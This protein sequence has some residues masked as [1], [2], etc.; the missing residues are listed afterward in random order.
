MSDGTE[1][2]NAADPANEL[3]DLPRSDPEAPSTA[4]AL[5][6]PSLPKASV[7]SEPDGREPDRAEELDVTRTRHPDPVTASASPPHDPSDTVPQVRSP[8]RY[9]VLGEHGRGGL[10]KVSRVRD[11]ELGR[12]VAIKELLS[13]SELHEVRFLREALIT[14]RLEHPVLTARCNS[15]SP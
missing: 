10:G 11:R 9:R 5:T 1:H 7:L 12:D 8:A 3:P 6:F 14:A 4:A 13:R 15:S 2:A